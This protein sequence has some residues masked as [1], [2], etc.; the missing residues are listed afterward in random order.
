MVVDHMD[1]GLPLPSPPSAAKQADRV[2]QKASL[3]VCANRLPLHVETNEGVDTWIPSTGGLAT[4]LT[5]ALQSRRG[6]WIGSA[7]EHE[8][9][10]LPAEYEGIGLAQVVLTAEEHEAFYLGFSNATLW[11]LYH[12]AVR[13]PTF[14][15]RWWHAYREV[16]Q[17][18]AEAAAEAAAPG[19]TVWV[20]DYQLQLV[21]QMLRELRS[22]VRIG[23]FLH[24]PFP[25][26][27]LFM[28]LPW[29]RDL[30]RGILGADLVGFQVPGAALNFSRLTRQ[31]L[32][33]AGT[34]SLVEYDGR[35]IMVGAFPISID[36]AWF[37]ERSVVPSVK[38]RSE[39]IRRELGDPSVL[40]LGV[41]RLDYTKGIEQ[42][43]RAAAELYDDGTLSADR[44]TI[45][46]IAVP[47]R[48]EDAHYQDERRHL[49]EVVSK[50][51]G[52]HADLGHPAVHYLYQ[53]VKSDEL[54]ALYLAADVM[55]VT[56]LRD[57]MNLVAK[58][59]VACRTDYTGRLVLSEFAGASS[60]LSG[61]FLV[62]PHDIDGLKE[63][64]RE[65]LNASDASARERMRRMHKAV[66]NRNVNDWAEEFL[67]ALEA[68]GA[69]GRGRR[70]LR[71][72]LRARR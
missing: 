48:Q 37:A 33:A 36:S 46:Q 50:V 52:E 63:V 65:A 2:E 38:R 57:G 1:D 11:P 25:P 17:R 35:S 12:D 72:R 39:E 64:I 43:I 7:V 53:R 15:R 41:D 23:F 18:F 45:V 70:P 28:Q 27:E 58:E 68:P 26:V 20:H 40:L 55:L 66:L 14:E 32:G 29:R 6:T 31:L 5:A 3:V 13:P 54:V 21:P 9:E 44:H 34:N 61:A 60:E 69:G 56:P 71:G 30:V 47:S 8:L 22:D 67:A 42:R 59:Y 51:N 62:N 24:I 49:E 19:A 10:H 16:N 4:A